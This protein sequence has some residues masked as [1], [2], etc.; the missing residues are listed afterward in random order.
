MLITTFINGNAAC[1]V[2]AGHGIYTMSVMTFVVGTP[3]TILCHL[4]RTPEP[5]AFWLGIPK[6][7]Y[8]GVSAI[9]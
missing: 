9:L 5:R 2:V 6:I 3:I 4:Q 1:I 7:A 8:K